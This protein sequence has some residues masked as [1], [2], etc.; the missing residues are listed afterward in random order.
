MPNVYRSPSQIPASDQPQPLRS[1]S[2]VPTGK[3]TAPESTR[4]GL[5]DPGG[6]VLPISEGIGQGLR[7]TLI[8][9][10]LFVGA[11]VAFKVI[12]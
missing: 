11:S 9:V 10:G 12:R 3:K 7:L 8:I 4:C 5:L 1:Q 2:T 6:C